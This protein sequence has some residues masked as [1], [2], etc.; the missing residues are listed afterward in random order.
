MN[1][2]AVAKNL[3]IV[4]FC[5]AGFML[6]SWFL[7]LYHQEGDATAF[8][9]TICLLLITGL[10]LFVQKPVQK[11]LF[12]RD[13]VAIV[14][15]GWLAM[16]FFGTL[17]FVISGAIPDWSAAFFE[18]VSGFT[19]TGATI[20]PAVEG[21]PHGIL[22]WRSFT[23]WIG[24]MGVLVLALAIMPSAGAMHILRAESPGPAPDKL[25]PKMAQTAKILYGIYLALTLVQVL[26]L[27]GAGMNVF[28][29]FI[30]AFG[31]AGTGGFS[32]KNA[33]V[34]AYDSLSIELIIG[35]FMLLF[36]I[37][38]TVH[39]QL[40][41][42]NW[43]QA[44]ADEELRLYLGFVAAAVLL[45]SFDVWRH[46]LLSL[47]Q[48]LRHAFFQVSSIITTTGYTTKDF[49]Q[50]PVLSKGVIVVLMFLGASAGST[51]GGLKVIRV[52]LLFKLIRR[53]LQR[54]KHPRLVKGILVNKRPVDQSLLEAA[55]TFILFYLLIFALATLLIAPQTNDLVTAST[56]VLSCLSNIGPGLGDVGPAASFAFFNPFGKLVLSLCMLI[57]RLE[58]MPV[59]LLG[60]PSFW[61]RVGL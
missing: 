51:G 6:P 28:D 55:M 44:L 39:Y 43:R 24:G 9:I 58:I 61:R 15:L 34:G 60:M 50:W 2:R 54:S 4:L 29:S 36:G 11:N 16:S 27:L 19:T 3:G 35:V 31:T 22:F 41:R 26:F 21:L 25:V 23:H 46:Q 45:I 56:A 48:A 32:N 52:L 40:V 33:S 5:Q 1:Y 59:V 8:L 47:P 53:E 30:H 57:G 10:P 38:F 13:G 17:P 49:N 7:A 37:S 42:K 18:A 20:L 12:A 14:A